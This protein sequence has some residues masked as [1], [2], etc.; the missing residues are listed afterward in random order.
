MIV[1]EGMR[2]RHIEKSNVRVVPQVFHKTCPH[3]HKLFVLYCTRHS[4]LV[5]TGKK[6]A[7]KARGIPGEDPQVEFP[8]KNM[9]FIP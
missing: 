1:G 4:E 3:H 7:L 9:W 2:C 8:H 5:A 6:R